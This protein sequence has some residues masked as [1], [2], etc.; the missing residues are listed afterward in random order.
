MKYLLSVLSLL[1]IGCSSEKIVY[2]DSNTGKE[3]SQ[4]VKLEKFSQEVV[5]NEFGVAYYFS[6]GSSTG[7]IYDIYTPVLKPAFNNGTNSYNPAVTCEEYENL[8]QK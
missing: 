4:K 6:H 5:C 2:V 7:K 8:K 1:L 3:I